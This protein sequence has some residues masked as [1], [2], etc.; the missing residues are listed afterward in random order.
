MW[1]KKRGGQNTIKNQYSGRTHRQ[2]HCLLLHLASSHTHPRKHHNHSFSL[3]PSCLILHQSPAIYLLLPR[4]FSLPPPGLLSHCW[5]DPYLTSTPSA[6]WRT[7]S[8]PSRWASTETTSSTQAL[9]PCSWWLKWPQSEFT[10]S[11]ANDGFQTHMALDGHTCI[12]W[13]NVKCVYF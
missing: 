5:T 2:A 1:F 7:G 9:P 8:L 6:Q 4:S 12:K 13:L 10:C 3:K 11:C